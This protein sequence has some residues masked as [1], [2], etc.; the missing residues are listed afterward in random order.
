MVS[1][2][3]VHSKIFVIKKVSGDFKKKRLHTG[4][5]VTL[6]LYIIISLLTAQQIL[7]AMP[8]IS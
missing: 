5:Q 2:L 7:R 3:Q 8:A 6:T 1:S 4:F